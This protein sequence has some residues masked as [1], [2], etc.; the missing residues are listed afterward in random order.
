MAKGRDEGVFRACP[1]AAL[2]I[3]S[4]F[5]SCSGWFWK[6]NGGRYEWNRDRIELDAR[7]DSLIERDLFGIA[8]E[9]ADS[10]TAAGIDDHRILGQKALVLGELGRIDE[11]VAVFETAILKDY[12]DCENHLNFAV[13]L[14]RM[15]KT[16]RAVTEFRVA[17]RFCGDDNRHLVRRNLAVAYIKQGMEDEALVEVERGLKHNRDDPYLMGL[18]GMLIMNRFPREARKLLVASLSSGGMN[19]EFL[20][21]LGLIFLSI[22]RPDEA[23]DVFE[24]ALELAPSDSDVRFYSAVALERAGRYDEAEN[25]LRKLLSEGG[26]VKVS[27]ALAGVLFEQERFEDALTIYESLGRSPEVLDRIAMCHKG[28]GRLEEAERIE[29]E[30]LSL[31]PGW[32]AAMLNLA[33]ILAARG[34]LDEAVSTLEQII[35]LEPENVRARLNLD[36]LREAERSR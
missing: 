25:L 9:L 24:R 1:L 18:K 19:R 34:E 30:V 3:L 5:L 31:R 8:L 29:R 27:E 35:E 6:E 16:G 20:E 2:I 26:G 22:D 11:S 13:V 7:I 23:L 14:M 33:V 32:T 12:E 17:D 10:V 21:Q 15:G 28:L 36:L 4:V